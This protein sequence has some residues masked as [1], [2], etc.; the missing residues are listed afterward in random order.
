MD[1]DDLRA[2]LTRLLQETAAESCEEPAG[3]GE[4]AELAQFVDDAESPRPLARLAH[5]AARQGLRA[6]DIGEAALAERWLWAGIDARIEWL[7]SLMSKAKLKRFSR[8]AKPRGMKS[9]RTKRAGP[10][11]PRGRPP[12]KI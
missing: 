4:P 7:T 10:A 6:L 1:A 12:K 3:I 5:G 9:E 8:P 11:R 2:R